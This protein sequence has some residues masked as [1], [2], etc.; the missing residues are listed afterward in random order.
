[1]Q[2]NA[3]AAAK[4]NLRP[5][6]IVAG[7]QCDDDPCWQDLNCDGHYG[8][9]KVVVR[10]SDDKA[11]YAYGHALMKLFTASPQLRDALQQIV[12]SE[13]SLYDLKQIA[14]EALQSIA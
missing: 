1:M 7:E 12:A 10:M 13:G 2:E 9:V 4:R 5:H 8:A 11:D 3:W 6:D 14:K